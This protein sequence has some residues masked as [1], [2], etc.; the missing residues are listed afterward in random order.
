M[1]Q[2]RHSPHLPAPHLPAPRQPA[3]LPAKSPL[4][5]SL[6][7]ARPGHTPGPPE[8]ARELTERAEA[9]AGVTLGELARALGVSVPPDLRRN[10]GW[11][12]QLLEQALGADAKS[13]AEP[14]FTALGIELKTLPVD[15]RGRPLESTFVCTIEL[16]EIGSGEWLQSRVRDKL[17]RV[18][19]VP[20]QGERQ[21]PLGER[22]IGTPLLWTL[23]GELEAALRCDWE[24]LSGLIGRGE[25]ETLTGHLGRYLQVRPKGASSR[26]RRMARDADGVPYA[27]LPRGFYLR[28]RFTA[29]LLEQHFALPVATPTAPSRSH[30]HPARSP[31]G[32]G[33]GGRDCSRG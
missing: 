14:D 2:R 23:S 19:W 28:A 27:E 25:T 6:R 32:S 8:S 16:T 33:R 30:G 21:M 13:R 20:V 5:E 22:C 18:L 26:S 10:K 29:L 7:V 17:A 31:D 3:E 9:L 24:E 12:G 4:V 15:G 1:H 11:V